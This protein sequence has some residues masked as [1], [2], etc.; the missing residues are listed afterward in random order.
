MEDDFFNDAFDNLMPYIE[1][2]TKPELPDI[3][4]DLEDINLKTEVFLEA[5]LDIIRKVVSKA[6]SRYDRGVIGEANILQE[7]REQTINEVIKNCE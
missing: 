3:M 4:I 6:I 1:N 5:E 7:E 2:V